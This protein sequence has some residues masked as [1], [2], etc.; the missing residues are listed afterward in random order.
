MPEVH[1]LPAQPI[2]Y[3]QGQTND[4][5]PFSLAIAA[6]CFWPGRYP[7]ADVARRLARYR[8]PRLGA[9]LPWGLAGVGRALGLSVTT[10]WLGQLRDLKRCVDGGLP[11]I[12]LV[13]PSDFIGT[14]WYT[15]HYRVVVG[16][17]DDVALPG[18]GE[19]Y[20]ACSGSYAESFGD[21]RPGN[22]A[23]SYQLLL[24]QWHTWLTPR[25]WATVKP[26]N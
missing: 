11:A 17:R 18:G 15:L 6:S 23:I 4:C 8:V 2:L 22:V 3:H 14:P 25:W 13:H 21:E 20:F 1:A 24:G 10:G 5:G 12:V 16:Y 9:S 26:A 19:V 7:P